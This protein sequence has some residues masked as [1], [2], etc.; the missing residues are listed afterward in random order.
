MGVHP[1]VH[2]P[3]EQKPATQ[4]PNVCYFVQAKG[5]SSLLG[6]KG[7]GLWVQIFTEG[8]PW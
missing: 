7:I 8:L 5:G 3:V 2:W 6:K 4:V 1:A